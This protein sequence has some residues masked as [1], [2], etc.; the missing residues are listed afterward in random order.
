MASEFVLLQ[1]ASGL[2]R[3][4]RGDSQGGAIKDSTVAQVSAALYYQAN[5]LANLTTSKSFQKQFRETIFSQIQKDF[6]EYLDAKARIEPKSYH[7]VYEWKRS[8]DAGARLFNLAIREQ[9]GLSFKVGYDFKISKSA[10]PTNTGNNRHVFRN[11]A[12]VMEEGGPLIISP[13]KAE[14]LVFEIR[15]SVVFMPKGKSV[16][17]SRAGGGKTTSRFKIAYAQFFKGQLVSNSI[18]RSGFQNLFNYKL[19]RAMKLPSDIKTVKYTF[20]PNTVAMQAKTGLDMAF[21]V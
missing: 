8:G 16:T 7:H 20:S 13:K 21:G 3:L 9:E 4:M 10:V 6:G 5:V 18:K 2:G 12:S 17:I 14:R 19:T 11:K 15:G 1:A